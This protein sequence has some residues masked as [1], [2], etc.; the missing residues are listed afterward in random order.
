MPFNNNSDE[1]YI[2][3]EDEFVRGSDQMYSSNTNS[4]SSQDYRTYS[5]GTFEHLLMPGENILWSGERDMTL[6]NGGK[7]GFSLFSIIAIVMVLITVAGFVTFFSVLK[8]SFVIEFGDLFSTSPV[9]TIMSGMFLLIPIILIVTVISNI[10][11]KGKK[12]KSRLFEKYAITGKRV[13]LC[14]NNRAICADLSDI[15]NIR[16]MRESSDYGHILFIIHTGIM[17]C[18]TSSHA[19]TM[20][21][22]G[23]K[24]FYNIEHP[25]EVAAILEDAIRA[26]NIN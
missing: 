12:S 17:Y 10:S 4:T 6:M 7:G 20:R 19:S 5:D 2:R 14:Y 1:E 11:G 24:A 9:I 13:L 23:G 3:S 8:N 26:C 15:T 25:S 16:V 21:I 18:G 22:R